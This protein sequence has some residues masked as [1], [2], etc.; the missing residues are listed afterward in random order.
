MFEPN[1]EHLTQQA[2]EKSY[3]G[4][5]P[6]EIGRVQ[7]ELL[8]L[9]DANMVFGRVIDVGC[10]TGE[11]AIELAGR[12][13]SVVGVD[14]APTAIARAEAKSAERGVPVDFRI[15]DALRLA[16][17]GEVFDTAID[18]GVFHVFSDAERFEYVESLRACL[19]PG[20]RLIL[21]CFS[22]KEHR[23]GGPRRISEQ[24]LRHAFAH[25]WDLEWLE[26]AR[27]ESLIHPGGAAAWLAIFR[28]GD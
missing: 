16:D 28:R 5:P 3:S 6:W 23:E 17:L 20:G 22:D 24:E 19:N 27:F 9:I 10:G 12:G 13:F 7:P 14:C 21:F 11:L 25:G 15:H 8:R 1:P 4:T 26:P 2:F 18:C